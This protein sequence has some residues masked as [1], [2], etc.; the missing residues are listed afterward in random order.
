MHRRS[1][2]RRRDGSRVPETIARNPR[3]RRKSAPAAPTPRRKARRIA[4]S[5]VVAVAVAGT[6]LGFSVTSGRS[7]ASGDSLT[8]QVNAD[9]TQIIAALARLGFRI[10]RGADSASPSRDSRPQAALPSPSHGP[11]CVGTATGRVRTFLLGKH[12]G[13]NNCKESASSIMTISR[14]GVTTRVVITWVVLG[15]ANL[16]GQYEDKANSPHQGAGNPPGE[17]PK[18]FDGDCYASGRNGATVWTEQVHLTGSTT[19]T[20]QEILRAMAPTT[21]KLSPRYLQKNCPD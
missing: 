5:A 12:H 21:T 9:L 14:Q 15:D 19:N 11:A 8:V 6:G 3:R 2:Y 4:L 10:A 1:A 13:K 7:A 20:D 16:A 18:V 17:P